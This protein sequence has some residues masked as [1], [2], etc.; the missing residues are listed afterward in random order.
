MATIRDV[1]RRAG[2]SVSTV[3]LMI[4]GK[5]N[6]SDEKYARIEQAMK[7]LKYRPSIIAQNLKKRKFHIIGVILPT[8]DGYYAQI[9]KGIYDA[10]NLLDEQYDLII[11]YSGDN[12]KT[13]QEHIESLISMSVSGI[14]LVPCDKRNTDQYNEWLQSGI[15]F[16]LLE[17]TVQSAEISSVVFNNREIIYQKTKELLKKYSYHEI[18]LV[19]G[20]SK[21]SNERDCQE[22]FKDA[23]LEMNPEA[24]PGELHILETSFER[25]RC[26]WNFL[27]GFDDADGRVRCVLTSSVKFAEILWEVLEIIHVDSE[28]YALSGDSWFPPRKKLEGIQLIPRETIALGKEAAKLLLSLIRT[29]KISEVRDIVVESNYSTQ[30]PPTDIKLNNGSKTKIKALLLQTNEMNI[31]TKF[32]PNFV[33]QTG[34]EIEFDLKPF[35]TLTSILT[36]DPEGFKEYDVLWVDIPLVE[37][38]S[39][40]GK[41]EKLNKWVDAEDKDLIRSFPKGVL[42]CVYDSRNQIYGIPIQMEETLLYYRNSVFHDPAIKRQFF[43]KNGFELNPPTTWPEFNIIAKFFDKRENPDSPFEYGTA[44]SL[45]GHSFM[46]EFYLRQWAFNGRMFDKRRNLVIDSV[47][48]ARALRSFAETFRY[49]HP[50]SVGYFFDETYLSLLKGEVPMVV[51]FPVHCIPYR[52]QEIDESNEKDIAAAQL[53]GGHPLMGGWEFCINSRSD[54][55]EEAFQFIKWSVREDMAVIRDL[56]GSVLPVKETFRNSLLNNY[57][58]EL[59]MMDTDNFQKGLRESFRDSR[60]NLIDQHY[61]E[62]K[63][64]NVLMK[65]L[66]GEMSIEDALK[67]AHSAAK[68][69]VD[70]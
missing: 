49:A 12:E 19:T 69:L 43:S 70:V 24:D 53:P 33:K 54:K 16:V 25:R 67:Q 32:A 65:A 56:M 34:I 30:D 63:L 57:F 6:I 35:D 9:L 47:E 66:Y 46:E 8:A 3:S 55:K 38:M 2:V 48:N 31:L 50:E 58:P 1:A 11:K 23:I 10:L 59:K 52:Y 27:Q 42:K 15:F 20:D 4:N 22:G 64:K 68:E 44:M 37:M 5:Q 14:I 26:V 60:G 17:R 62:N 40:Q 45:I 18:S 36:G 39:R 7:E 29:N 21:Y 61:V 51:N 13:E 41:L 28:V